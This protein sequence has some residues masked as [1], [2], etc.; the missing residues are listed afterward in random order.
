[1]TAMIVCRVCGYDDTIGMTE[2]Y[3]DATCACCGS[4]CLNLIHHNEVIAELPV[5]SWE[6][7]ADGKPVMVSRPT[8]LMLVD[9][10]GEPV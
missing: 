1:M 8:L 2:N 7:T 6:I 9:A 3:H 4:R 10:N 5:R